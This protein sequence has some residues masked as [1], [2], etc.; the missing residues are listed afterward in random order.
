MVGEFESAGE[1]STSQ[2]RLALWSWGMD[3]VRE[4]PVLG[5]GYYNWLNYCY[6][7]NPDGIVGVKHCLAAHNTY[8]TAAAEI[9]IT[10]LTVYVILILFILILNIRTRANA[11][12]RNNKFILYTAHGLD[13]GLIGYMIATIFFSVLFYPMLYV[14]LAMTVALHEISKK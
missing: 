13:A 5:V 7:D 10:G 14:Q 1:D 2:A 6:F 9:G 3:V 4:F 11:R 8:V 12:Q